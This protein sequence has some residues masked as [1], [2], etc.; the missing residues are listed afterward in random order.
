MSQRIKQNSW[1]FNSLSASIGFPGSSVSKE[2]AC[3]AGDRFDPWVGKIPGEGN[4]NLLQDSCLEN[5]MDRGP[6]GVQSRGHKELDTT[7]A[8][9]DVHVGSCVWLFSTLWTAAHQAPLS[10]GFSR[11][12]YWSGLP[13]P[14][15]GDLPNPG[16]KLRFLTSP[17]L[18]GG[19]FTT[20]TTWEAFSASTPICKVIF[21]QHPATN[22]VFSDPWFHS[23]VYMCQH[24]AGVIILK[25]LGKFSSHSK[26]FAEWNRV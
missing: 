11:Q 16:I 10:M 8:T 18:A 23:S 5:P 14:P 1:L 2:S 6:G 25:M 12:E 24:M 9:Q 7:E 22:M 15:P 26:H 20:S 19:F 3:S 4:G 21:V 13:C 17:A